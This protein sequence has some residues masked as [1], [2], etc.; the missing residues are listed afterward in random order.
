MDSNLNSCSQEYLRN[1]AEAWLKRFSDAVGQAEPSAVAD[2]VQEDGWF[3][4]LLTFTW[5]FRSIHQ[6][7]NVES[8]LKDTLPNAGLTDVRLD[9]EYAP[10]IG[11]FGPSRTVVDVALKFDTM[12]AHG[13]GFVRISLKDDVLEKPEAFG[14]FLMITDWKGH[15]EIDHE[16]GIYG[17]HTIAWQDVR[18]AQ[19]KEI[20]EA[21]DVLIVGAGQTGLQ[22]A[23][24]FH[25]MNIKAIIIEKNACVG[26]NW[27]NH[28]PTLTLHTP[29]TYNS[30]LYSP[31][32]T[33]APKFIPKDW[34]AT[35]LEQYAVVQD[36]VVWTSSFIEPKPTYDE[37]VGRWDV[38]VDK[39]GERVRLRPAHIVI[40]TSMHGKPR[41]PVVPGADIFDGRIL[42][43]TEFHGGADF[44]SDK[45]VVVGVGNS[46]ADVCQDLVKHGASSVTMVQR[47]PSSVVSD[48]LV[49]S[50][51]DPVY[52]DGQNIGYLDLVAN[53]MPLEA[54]RML[55]KEVRESRLAFDKEMREGLE[56]AGFRL[57]DGDGSGQLFLVY[58]KGGG[59]FNDVGCAQLIIDGQVKVKHGNEIA[60]FKPKKVVFT[61]GTE[62]EADAVIFA[63]GW[64]RVRS[65]LEDLFGKE[66]IDRTSEIWGIDEHGELRIGY[67][68]SGQPGFWYAFGTFNQSRFH[69]KQ[70][71]GFNF[72]INIYSY[73]LLVQALLIKAIE[74]GYFKYQD[75]PPTKVDVS[76]HSS[77]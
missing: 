48:K 1:I 41:V 59:Y 60:A 7:K 51:L 26:D 74:L 42:H 43:S 31:F 47:S 36:L 9:G 72:T 27:R 58:E 13:K 49:A 71:V 4:D 10:R 6:R 14:L 30:F 8:Y 21:P 38:I 66:T 45:V 57:S 34:L 73:F 37:S 2:C 23:A 44:T 3:R 33:N 19:R 22:L 50:Q 29:K 63:T 77:L 64:N 56:K 12:K 39:Q 20:E 24:R 11:H 61:D 28:Y 53:A 17:G 18:A 46:A 75:A 62:I 69:A 68:S 16:S 32:P 5:D 25:Q 15:E 65:D 54:M 70:L 35:W 52:P 76:L 55:M 67:R 40:A